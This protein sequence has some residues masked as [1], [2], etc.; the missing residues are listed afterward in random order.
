M[1]RHEKS[2]YGVSAAQEGEGEE[3][4]EFNDRYSSFTLL[5]ILV[6]GMIA[7]ICNTFLTVLNFFVICFVS[8]VMVAVL[9]YHVP[10]GI[11]LQGL[12]LN[13]AFLH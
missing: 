9:G 8:S 10:D 13:S 11:G 3:E 4:G 2:S 12:A 5:V 7:V 1:I 6:M